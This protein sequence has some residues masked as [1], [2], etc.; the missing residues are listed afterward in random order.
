[1][2]L[3]WHPLVGWESRAEFGA[4][5]NLSRI[6]TCSRKPC[7]TVQCFD[8]FA[9][10]NEWQENLN[11]MWALAHPFWGSQDWK[12]INC[13]LC[14]CWNHMI[15]FFPRFYILWTQI[16]FHPRL[17]ELLMHHEI[18]E[19]K[20]YLGMFGAKTWK[21]VLLVSSDPCVQQLARPANAMSMGRDMSTKGYNKW[22]M[23]G[24]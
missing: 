4:H 13:Q 6:Y 5:L 20:T 16:W 24:L 2:H 19:C 8:T 22:T 7:K 3:P 17:R 9:F 21:H 15:E 23:G 10:I 12:K 18:F 11:S 1:M 14:N